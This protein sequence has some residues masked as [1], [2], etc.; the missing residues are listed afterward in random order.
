[1]DE[2][3]NR[4]FNDTRDDGSR[5]YGYGLHGLGNVLSRLLTMRHYILAA[6][7]VLA[8][9]ASQPPPPQIVKVIE[10][11]PKPAI[12]I[13]PD[14][15][16]DLSPDIQA[17]I[18]GHQTP[19]LQDGIAT[20]YPYSPNTEWT[21]YCTAL[22]ATE[23]RLNP[24]EHTDKD[25]VVLGD[26]LRWAIKVSKQAVMVEPL[27]TTADPHMVSNLIIATNRRSYH[28]I[29]K[30]RSKPMDAVAFYYPD[31]VRELQAARQVA[32]TEAAK[33]AADPPTSTSESA[34]VQK[35]ASTQ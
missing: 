29:V 32:Q 17:A 9:C 14:P 25:S 2:K 19:T 23:I 11:A 3:H 30:L 27:G 34:P 8:G 20:I 31:D 28:F 10:P 18:K 26:S 7:I 24:D 5:T 1:M 16:A 21:I 4:S 15:M 6:A 22:S 12:V 13:P 35:E 33:E